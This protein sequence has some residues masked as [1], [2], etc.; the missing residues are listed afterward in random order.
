MGSSAADPVTPSNQD[1]WDT[2]GP[3]AG[4]PGSDP[5]GGPGEHPNGSS[6]DDHLGG[7][8]DSGSGEYPQH[9]TGNGVG[10]DPDGPGG[11]GRGVDYRGEKQIKVLACPSTCLLIVGLYHYLSPYLPF[12]SVVDCVVLANE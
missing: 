7:P 11:E 1:K 12:R 6:A 10:H 5:T 9:P 3:N 4:G 8:G 2:S